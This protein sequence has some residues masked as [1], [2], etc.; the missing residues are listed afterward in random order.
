MFLSVTGGGK[1]R[2]HLRLGQAARDQW[3]E[4]LAALTLDT[5]QLGC[6]S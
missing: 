2:G 4:Q 1:G 6:I 3:K 5:Y